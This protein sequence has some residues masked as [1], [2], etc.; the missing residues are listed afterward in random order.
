MFTDG[1]YIEIPRGRAVEE[2]IHLVFVAAGNS[3]PWA[4]YPRNLIVAGEGSQF[5]GVVRRSKDL[6]YL[7]NTVTEIGC[8]ALS[9]TITKPSANFAGFR[10]C[11]IN[12]H[13]E[14]DSS[15][16]SRTISLGGF[17]FA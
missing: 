11:V 6:V 10:H 1:A 17:W 4:C 12:A 14:R 3:K 15:L 2:P 8:P 7:T 16:T 5:T 9:S 13:L